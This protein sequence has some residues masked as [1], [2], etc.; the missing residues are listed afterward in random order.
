MVGA[1]PSFH[2]VGVLN[3]LFELDDSSITLAEVMSANGYRTGAIIGNPIL[4][5]AVGFDQGFETY[6]DDLEGRELNRTGVRERA[7]DRVVDLAQTWFDGADGRPGF[8]WLHFQDP[9]GPYT[10]PEGWRPFADIA[11]D[12]TGASLPVGLDQSG[13]GAIPKYQVLGDERRI[14]EYVR[15]YDSEIAFFDHQLGRLLSSLSRRDLLESTLIVLTA[16]HGEA[17]GEDGFYFGHSQSVGL[18]QVSVPLV[19]AGPGVPRELTVETPVSNVTLMAS[20]LD[21]VGIEA[22]PEIVGPTLAGVF[23]EPG[24]DMAPV[25][26]ETPNQSGVVHGNAYLRHDRRPADD[27]SFWTAGNPNTGGFWR[28]L[29]RELVVPLDPGIDDAQLATVGHLEEMLDRFDDDAARSRA[30]LE[31]RRVPVSLPDRI[32]ERLRALGY[33]Q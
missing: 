28:P 26:F 2:T 8:L 4:R 20:I 12:R 31:D 15:R 14:A 11:S 13:Y 21:L 19:M 10:S 32:L 33:V 29:G 16:D 1:Y 5:A 23:A 17:F 27:E 9:H 7:A 6:D 25:F 30:E 3:G 24:H 18:D 22:P